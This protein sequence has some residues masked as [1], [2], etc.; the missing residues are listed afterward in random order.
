MNIVQVRHI[1]DKNA[2]RYTYKVPDNESLNKGD[3]VLTRNVNGKESV[4]I[5]VTDSENLSTNAIDMIMCGAEV[6]S[7]VIGEYKFYKFETNDAIHKG[8]VSVHTNPALLIHTTPL[9]ITE[10]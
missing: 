10:A 7:E 9:P 4:A 8:D 1:Q 6:L 5:C 3:M 2:K